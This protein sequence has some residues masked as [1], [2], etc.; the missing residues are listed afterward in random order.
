MCGLPVGLMP[1]S[2]IGFIKHSSKAIQSIIRHSGYS[3]GF[4][5]V[6]HWVVA[7]LGDLTVFRITDL[8]G[9]FFG[10]MDGI[11]TGGLAEEGEKYSILNHY[12]SDMLWMLVLSQAISVKAI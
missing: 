1:V 7:R 4:L 9:M 11:Q 5:L 12:I 8:T 6:V 3:C 2:E 10:L